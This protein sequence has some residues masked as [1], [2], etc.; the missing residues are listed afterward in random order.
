MSQSVGT[1]FFTAS[2][3][4]VI[5]AILIVVLVVALLL[6]IFIALYNKRVKSDKRGAVLTLI[7]NVFIT[8]LIPI[9]VAMVYSLYQSIRRIIAI[10]SNNFVDIVN[11]SVLK[12]GALIEEKE[13]W[14]IASIVFI[15]LFV[16]SILII[17]IL[18]KVKSMPPRQK[19]E[20]NEKKLVKPEAKVEAESVVYCSK[21]GYK[22]SSENEFCVG[23][24]EKLI[25]IK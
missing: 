5:I 4:A 10:N 24:G 20:K 22:N 15:A 17:L 21:C 6:V 13:V 9:S 18:T 16:L 1:T 3:I 19:R 8:V 2:N 7:R 12:A 25:K 11:E 23:C 14:L